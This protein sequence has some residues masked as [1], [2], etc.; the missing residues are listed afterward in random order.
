ME[1]LDIKLEDLKPYKNNPRIN[2][3]AVPAVAKS[4]QEFGFKVPIV[5]D[6]DN[7]IIAGHTRYKAAHLL[8]LDTVPCIIA[9]DLSDAQVAAFRLADNKVGELA[10]WDTDLLEIELSSITDFDMCDFGFDFSEAHE[11]R[12]I[13]E[14]DYDFDKEVEPRAKRGELW[15]LGRHRLMCG[16][17]INQADISILLNG[18]QVDLVVTD[19]PYNMNYSGAGKTSNRASK[20]ILNDHMP[21]K[22]FEQFLYKI[23]TNLSNNLKNGCC[24]YMFYK[25]L[26]DGSFITSLKNTGLTFKQ[27]LIWVKDHLVLGGSKYQ[28]MYEPCLFGCKGESVKKWYT[29]RKE[30]SVIESI[31]LMDEEDLRHTIKKLL[32]QEIPDII[33][34]EK[35]LKNDL[36][37]TMK[38]IKLLA[39]FI[40]NSSAVDD[41]VLDLFGGSGSTMIACEQLERSCMMLEMEPRFVD[42]I[43]DRWEAF[44]GKKAVLL[45]GSGAE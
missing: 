15:Q 6:H 43:I 19:P 13:I 34:V 30:T 39:K 1:I 3:H 35:P 40:V 24:F 41:L 36:H 44:T 20:K 26:G 11:Q 17:S 7:V 27:E 28:S 38:P 25:E 42:V 31:D 8:G 29:G 23:N 16:D 10:N 9:S 12:E 32:N 4:I 18:N 21:V 45:N 22:E 37:P 33:R 5:I 2:D 14:D